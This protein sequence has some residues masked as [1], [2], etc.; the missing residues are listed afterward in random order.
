MRVS[1]SILE[2]APTS[3]HLFST[4]PLGSSFR[5]LA[6][7]PCDT[8]RSRKCFSNGP[9]R[10]TVRRIGTVYPSGT[11]GLRSCR[12]FGGDFAG[13]PDNPST[14]CGG[15]WRGRGF[16][17]LP[18]PLVFS[19]TPF[20]VSSPTLWILDIYLRH[21]NSDSWS[22]LFVIYSFCFFRNKDSRSLLQII[23][24][25][26]MIYWSKNGWRLKPKEQKSVIYKSYSTSETDWLIWFKYRNVQKYYIIIN[27]YL[28]I[29][30]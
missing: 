11:G 10:H 2:S 13:R 8:A 14:L 6:R 19:S 29:L 28:I 30:S 18:F 5:S 27:S 12:T 9:Y 21:T 4:V 3:A 20:F 23:F 22:R 7:L 26:I 15:G 16:N 25:N 1:T 24:F 17:V